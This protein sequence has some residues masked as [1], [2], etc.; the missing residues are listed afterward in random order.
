MAY[1]SLLGYPLRRQAV[2]PRLHSLRLSP[3]HPPTDNGGSHHDDAGQEVDD[4]SC[5][6]AEHPTTPCCHALTGSA[7]SETR[8]RRGGTPGSTLPSS[9]RYCGICWPTPL[10]GTV[11]PA[12]K[13]TYDRINSASTIRTTSAM[14]PAVHRRALRPRASYRTRCSIPARMVAAVDGVKSFKAHAV[15]VRVGPAAI[16]HGSSAGIGGGDS[17]TRIRRLPCSR[18]L[19]RRGE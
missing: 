19:R 9:A 4:L 3:R 5:A 12:L 14:R 11:P 13:T 8:P 6:H 17:T 18:W 2:A 10:P 7:A 15:I 16:R 1:P